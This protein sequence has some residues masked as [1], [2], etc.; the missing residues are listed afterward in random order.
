MKFNLL[1]L[2]SVLCGLTLKSQCFVGKYLDIQY[3]MYKAKDSILLYKM[4]HSIEYNRW[5]KILLTSG[6]IEYSYKRSPNNVEFCDVGV[7][8]LEH[9]SWFLE[10]NI[11]TLELKSVSKYDSKNCTKIS[12]QILSCD[13]NLL[14]IKEV[15]VLFR[16][17]I[18]Y[19]EEREDFNY[20]DF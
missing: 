3:D 8:F 2:L 16:K 9:G 20:S 10:N 4:S 1:I 15:K 6:K 7:Y 5:L 19:L 14:E 12:Y 11:L 17:K 13:N 18:Q